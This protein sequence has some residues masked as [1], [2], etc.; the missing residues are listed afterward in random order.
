M[1]RSLGTGPA[2]DLASKLY[3]TEGLTT[4]GNAFSMLESL[5][6]VGRTFS[7]NAQQLE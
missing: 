3:S 7:G 4:S 1:G 2:V 5:K 6:K